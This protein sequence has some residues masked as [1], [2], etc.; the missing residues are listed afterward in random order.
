M[1][2]PKNLRWATTVPN[3]KGPGH[4]VDGDQ[5]GWKLHIVN[6]ETL[7]Q[8]TK[9]SPVFGAA[10]CG[11]RAKHGW[12]LDFFIEDECKRCL[13]RAKKLSLAIPESI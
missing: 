1:S 9:Q 4:G 8:A 2:G 5:R 7:Y 13:A 11:T 6:A 3:P 12:G 10:L